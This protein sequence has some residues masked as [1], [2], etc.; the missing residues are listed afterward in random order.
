MEQYDIRPSI[1][2]TYQA[3]AMNIDAFND[4][5]NKNANQLINIV[6]CIQT[7]GVLMIFA[8]TVI[9]ITCAFKLSGSGESSL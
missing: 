4:L 9:I 5:F 6:I 1:D 7:L 8:C 2:D 3:E